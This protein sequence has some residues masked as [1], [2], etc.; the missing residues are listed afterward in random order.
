MSNRTQ[1]VDMSNAS[2]EQDQPRIVPTR[3]GWW[4]IEADPEITRDEKPMQVVQ[5]TQGRG[6]LLVSGTTPNRVDQRPDIVWL[7]PIPGPAI[8]AALARYSEALDDLDA[9]WD[10]ADFITRNNVTNLAHAA[11]DALDDAIRAERGGG[12]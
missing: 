12:A 7:T 10:G 9:L 8:L 2:E 4:W 3:P 11:G 5:V 1:E 6:G